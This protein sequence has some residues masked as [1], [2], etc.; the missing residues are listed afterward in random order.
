MHPVRC[1][2]VAHQVHELSHCIGAG[3]LQLLRLQTE[4]KRGQSLRSG[5]LDAFRAEAHLCGL[6]RSKD[7]LLQGHQSRK[8]NSF[9]IRSDHRAVL[10]SVSLALS[11]QGE[12]FLKLWIRG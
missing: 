7:V 6:C 4:N 11:Q 1:S 9:P 5:V 2:A 3:Q 8:S 12:I 10:I